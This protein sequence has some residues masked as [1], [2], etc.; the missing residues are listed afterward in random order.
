MVLPHTKKSNKINYKIDDRS[1]I[2]NKYWNRIR[3]S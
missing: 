3:K 1:K 2:F